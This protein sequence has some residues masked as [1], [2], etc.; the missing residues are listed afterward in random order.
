MEIVN[1]GPVVRLAGDLDVSTARQLDAHA[2]SVY[3][4]SGVTF[5][6]CAGIAAL[7]RARERAHARGMSF[8]LE[9]VGD[10]VARVLE[11][12]RLDGVFSVSRARGAIS[13]AGAR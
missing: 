2:A 4:V 8:A 11:V 10:P 12:T 9:G 3:D 7:L 5:M 6:D 1:E 13:T